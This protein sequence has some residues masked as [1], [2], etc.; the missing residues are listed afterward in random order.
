VKSKRDNAFINILADKIT[1][2]VAFVSEWS[3]E[4]DLRPT[5]FARMGSNPIECIS[6][7]TFCFAVCSRFCVK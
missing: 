2:F 5:V 7:L 1:L 6:F 3:K 4:V